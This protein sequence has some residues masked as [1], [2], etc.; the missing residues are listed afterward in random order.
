MTTNETTPCN[1][2]P[3]ARDL[4]DACKELLGPSDIDACM[5]RIREVV[6]RAE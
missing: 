5:D 4:L 1:D 2:H 6:A 3:W